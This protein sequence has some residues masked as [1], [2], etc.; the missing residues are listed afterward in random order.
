M[1]PNAGRGDVTL[2]L[3]RRTKDG[4][5]AVF[6][7]EGLGT[8]AAVVVALIMGILALVIVLLVYFVESA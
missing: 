2:W 3:K 6:V 8:L 7:L 5:R 4:R 1:E